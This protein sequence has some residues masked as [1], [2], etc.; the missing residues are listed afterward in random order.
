MQCF[1][2]ALILCLKLCLYKLAETYI[3]L[4]KNELAECCDEIYKKPAEGRFFVYENSINYW[5]NWRTPC[6]TWL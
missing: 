5:S 2:V 1:L 3:K 6:G 4:Q